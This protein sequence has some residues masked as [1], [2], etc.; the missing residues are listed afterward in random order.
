VAHLPG[1]PTLTVC[2]SLRPNSSCRTLGDFCYG[3]TT[4][5]SC[6]YTLFNSARDC[7]PT[8]MTPAYGLIGKL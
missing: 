3:Y 8:S 1:G 5:G 4:S 2:I 6:E 7:C